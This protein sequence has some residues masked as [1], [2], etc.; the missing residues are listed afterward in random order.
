MLD[1]WSLFATKG[2]PSLHSSPSSST[3]QDWPSAFHHHYL[4]LAGSIPE[5]PTINII[6]GPDA[7]LSRMFLSNGTKFVEDKLAHEKLVERCTFF[8]S[9]EI[10]AQIQT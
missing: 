5:E 7:G 6:G 3:W 4:G 2:D 9:L 8:N 1:S 10:S